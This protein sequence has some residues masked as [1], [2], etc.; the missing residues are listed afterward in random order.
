MFPHVD[1]INRAM[2]A[3]LSA[4]E[5]VQ[6]DETLVRL[7]ANADALVTAMPLPKADRRRGGRKLPPAARET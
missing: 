6:L 3:A 7:Q 5:I 2:L 1:A 4:D